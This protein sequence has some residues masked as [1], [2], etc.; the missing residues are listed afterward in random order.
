VKEAYLVGAHGSCTGAICF[1]YADLSFPAC[2]CINIASTSSAPISAIPNRWG[3]IGHRAGFTMSPQ[4]ARSSLLSACD[5]ELV[6]D[7]AACAPEL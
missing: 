7:A 4:A 3:T 1:P 5:F 2:A 6:G